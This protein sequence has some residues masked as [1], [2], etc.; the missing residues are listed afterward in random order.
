MSCF[1]KS[2]TMNLEGKNFEYQS[3][4][5]TQLNLHQYS[6]NFLRVFIDKK[7]FP[8][9]CFDFTIFKMSENRKYFDIK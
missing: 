6:Q 1:D 4:F 9:N 3:F 8:Q 5:L 2:F 7:D